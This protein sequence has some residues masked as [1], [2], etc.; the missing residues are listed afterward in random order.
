MIDPPIIIMHNKISRH[1]YVVRN[2]RYTKIIFVA[3]YKL[4]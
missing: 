3:L 2:I 1:K 4:F